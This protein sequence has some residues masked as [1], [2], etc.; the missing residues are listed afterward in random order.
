MPKTPANDHRS[1]SQHRSEHAWHCASEAKKKLTKYPE[2]VSLVKKLP[3]MVAT[4]GLGQTLA[5]LAAKAKLPAESGKGKNDVNPFELLY[6]HLETWLLEERNIYDR[7]EPPSVRPV[8]L[9]LSC[10]SSLLYRRATA[11]IQAF[12][13]WLRRYAEAL[14]TRDTTNHDADTNAR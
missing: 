11:E 3:A 14:Q 13:T 2:Y 8:I 7:P 1:L 9:A 12:V 4:N 5:Y 6:Q 10:H